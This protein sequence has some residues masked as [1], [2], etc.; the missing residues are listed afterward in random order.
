MLEGEEISRLLDILGN[1]NRRRII[2]LLRQKPCFVTEISERLTISPKAVIEHLQLMERERI[3][4]SQNDERRRKYY[5]LTRDF[6]LMVTVQQHQVTPVQESG[7]LR[8]RYINS[9]SMLKRMISAQEKL[10]TNLEYLERDIDQKINEI[11]KC[12]KQL[13]QSEAE[14]NLI[15]TLATYDLTF[16]DLVE[17]TGLLPDELAGMI[18]KLMESGIVEKM[19]NYYRI[20]D[21]HVN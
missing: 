18:R 20:R 1:R 7:D 17:I 21:S 4:S 14:L 9:L 8:S 19:G 10:I 12:G 13:L 16:N 6:N 11:M 5:Y 15:I 2:Q 3:L